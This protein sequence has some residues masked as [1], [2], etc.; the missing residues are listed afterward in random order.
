MDSKGEEIDDLRQK[1]H[2]ARMPKEVNDEAVKQLKRLEGMHQDAAEASIVRTYLEWL[3]E[4]PWQKTSKD[5]IDLKKAKEILDEDHFDL[6]KV[7]DILEAEVLWGDDHLCKEIRMV[8][9]S[10]LLSDVLAFTKAGALLLT[11][12]VNPQIIRTAQMVDI[13]AICLVR[14]KEPEKATIKLA[15]EEGI[16]LLSTKL[17][18]YETCG[19]LYKNGL[20]GC[21][22]VREEM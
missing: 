16:P 14:G 12:L 1:I 2:K 8:S 17:P 19:K 20:A 11:G 21:S 5:N 3:I 9:A 22:E 10:D 15:E 6:E 4:L 7:K 13:C 18:M